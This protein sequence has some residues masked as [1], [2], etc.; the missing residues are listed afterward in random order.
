MKWILLAQF[1]VSLG[2]S[3]VLLHAGSVPSQ[4]MLLVANKGDRT[5]GII[6]PD[7]GK[8][9]AAVPEGGITG[10]EVIASPDGRTAYV[11]IYGDAGVGQP[12]SDGT[13]IVVIDIA[14]RKVTG[15]IDLG[16]GLRPHCAV[17]GPKDGLLYVTTENENSV[18]IIDPK[19][20]KVIGAVPTGQA[21]SHMLAIS[22]DGQRGYT[23]NVGPGT[24]SVL[25][26][27]RRKHLATIPIA[28]RTQRI[29]LSV[30]GKWA[31]T[32]DQT[33]P[34][35]AAIDTATNK[36]A[37]WISLPACGYGSAATPEGRW[38]VVAVPKA[39]KV[40]VVDLKTMRV[41][42]TVDVPP[43]PQMAVARPDGQIVYVSCD[44]SGQ[45]A[46]IRTSDWTVDKL[47]RAGKNADGLAWA[48]TGQD[49]AGTR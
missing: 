8:Q 7:L 3:S 39:N 34:R 9:V 48:A 46:A 45:V 36:V 21:E 27:V 2:L 23:A 1:V 19:T 14:S 17:I 38:V 28:P 44:L 49:A 43:T 42:R 29:S 41:A 37:H 6:D 10:H 13:S 15:N 30:G 32:A 12:G 18:T 35:L 5:L 26:M 25:D 24:V 4:G 40:A 11:P 47:I 20:L 16:R 31:F 22:R 33:Q